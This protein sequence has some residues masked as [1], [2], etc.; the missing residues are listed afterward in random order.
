MAW[1]KVN[2]N[3]RGKNVGD[4]T[5]RAV[6]IAFNI[7]W[8]QAYAD[9]CMMGLE[10]CDMPSA[11]HVWG[12]FLRKKGWV[13]ETV[14]DYGRDDYTVADF[15]RDNPSGTFILALDGHV[16]CV[17]DGDYCDAWDSGREIPQYFWTCDI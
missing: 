16:V 6:S 9:L 12:A 14:R 2:P 5:V 3:P 1:K 4:C 10:M 7:P 11:N 15:C 17:K 8:R 13:R